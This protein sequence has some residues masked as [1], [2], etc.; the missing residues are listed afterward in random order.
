MGHGQDF[1]SGQQQVPP[2]ERR[3]WGGISK[4]K[5]F[6][7]NCS[8]HLQHVSPWPNREETGHEETKTW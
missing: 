8:I 4:S 5:I 6:Y 2:A 3:R 1:V 7:D